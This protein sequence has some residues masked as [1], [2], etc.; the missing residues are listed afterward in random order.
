M[1]FFLPDS[2]DLIDPTFDFETEIGAG[3]RDRQTHD[4]YAHEVLNPTPI[5]GVL[6][7]KAIVDGEKKDRRYQPHDVARLKTEGA[8]K[9]LRF[10]RY[11]HTKHL[12]TMGDCGSFTY[13][14]QPEPPFSPSQ[15]TEFYDACRFDFG[16]SLDHV[17]LGYQP[18][19]AESEIPKEWRRRFELTLELAREFYEIQKSSRPRFRS[20]GAAQGWS[21][22][23]YAQAVR[24]LQKIGYRY[25]AI[26]G[27]VPLKTPE[28]LA[29]LEAVSEVRRQDTK[30]HLLGVT[31]C[32][33]IPAFQR[34]GAASFDSTSPLRQ[35]FMDRRDNFHTVERTYPAIRIP[36]V[37]K[38]LKLR[39]RIKTGEVDEKK[40]RKLERQALETVYASA[41][42]AASPE[43]ALSAIAKYENLCG[44]ASPKS[45]TVRY[46]ETLAHR[47]WENCPCVMCQELGVDVVLF[48]GSQRNYRRGFHNMHVLRQRLTL[49][50]NSG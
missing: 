47:P 25:I 17:I 33:E 48:R 50:E 15:V 26:G 37:D 5:D 45:L 28:I 2:H 29:C 31:R 12:K 36:Q 20:L 49:A 41:N 35:A 18:A 24:E 39:R 10:D 23:T 7:S 32:R 6:I 8:R 13:I 21:P 42:R 11:D 40:A 46:L 9:F 22:A 44:G 43:D 14:D 30:L 4:R 38:N 19:A 1:Q 16:I 34:F 27:F 3:K